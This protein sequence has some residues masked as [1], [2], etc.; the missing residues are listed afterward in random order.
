[1]TVFA[2]G[3]SIIHQGDGLTHTC[4]IPDVCKTPSPAGPVPIP[5]VN[6]AMSTNL[7]DGSTTVKI[8]S[9]PVALESSSIA[10]SSGDEAGTAGG[11]ISSKNMGKLSWSTSSPNVKFEGKG[12][13]RFTDVAGHNGNQDN[14]FTLAMG[15]PNVA[16]PFENDEQECPNCGKKASEH[17]PKTGFPLAED[18]NSKKAAEKFGD[19]I[20]KAP[21][22]T[23]GAK[24]GMVGALV[25]ECPPDNAQHTYVAVAGAPTGSSSFKGWSGV[26]TGAGMTPAKNVV[27]S[28]PMTVKTARGGTV[29]VRKPRNGKHPPGQCAAQ[30]LL[31]TAL[32]NGCKPKSMTETFVRKGEK[33]SNHSIPSCPTCRDNIA[34]M[35]CPNPPKE[36]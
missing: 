34:A 12:V 13:V 20:A 28:D 30:K 25:C 16:Y 7:T 22:K 33:N 24:M 18:D 23:T 14:T 35:L 32:D 6:V 10:L 1:M 17:D 15:N 29:Q 21:D 5:Y 4:P 2:N 8:Q 31:I 26:A 36:T 11:V 3:L 9:M 27:P 19:E